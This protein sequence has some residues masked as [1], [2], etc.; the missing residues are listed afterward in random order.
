MPPHLHPRSTATSTL[1]AGTLVA[2][3]A[4]VAMPHIFPCPRPR[5]TYADSDG[6]KQPIASGNPLESTKIKKDAAKTSSASE[7]RDV[8]APTQS[9]PSPIDEES[10]LFRQFQEE[11]KTLDREA[12]ACPVP[13]PG[14]VLGRLLGFGED[15]RGDARG[16]VKF[17]GDSR[18]SME[19]KN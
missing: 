17:R 7:S 13:K 8:P 14:G 9:K 10:A 19:S 15:E 4:V 6:Q 16:R 3:F 5:R 18:P 12:H 11:A 2:S 1:F